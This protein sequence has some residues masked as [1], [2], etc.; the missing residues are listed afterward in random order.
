MIR[1]LLMICCELVVAWNSRLP[2]GNL[3]D[4]LVRQLKDENIHVILY[5]LLAAGTNL[6]KL[7]SFYNQFGLTERQSI[8]N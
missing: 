8:S 3:W 5:Y 6:S 4:T 7:Q 1:C 2:I